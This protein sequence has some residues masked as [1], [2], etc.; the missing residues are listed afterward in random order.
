MAVGEGYL[1]GRIARD[2]AESVISK[3]KI[4]NH[5]G[6]EHAGDVGSCGSAATGSNFFGDTASAHDV[7]T[8]QDD[9]R[10]SGAGQVCG[11]RESIVAGA[12]NERVIHRL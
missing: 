7:P 12:N 6:A 10:V 4:A 11:S 8:F 9:S 5:F 2:H 1:E 3:T